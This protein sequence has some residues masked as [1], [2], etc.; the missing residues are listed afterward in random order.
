MIKDGILSGYLVIKRSTKLGDKMGFDLDSRAD[1][2]FDDPI[3]A[4]E[5]MRSIGG[6][7]IVIASRN[8]VGC[9]QFDI[10]AHDDDGKVIDFGF[11]FGENF[12]Q[13]CVNFFE[14]DESYD[15]STN[16]Y[17]GHNLFTRVE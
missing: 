5:H 8:I 4:V 2:V 15:V 10:H 7:G 1:H 12:H 11:E 14:G 6:I 3:D 17:N 9:T 16:T 13:A